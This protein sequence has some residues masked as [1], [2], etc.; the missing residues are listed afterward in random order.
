MTNAQM[1]AVLGRSITAVKKMVNE[2][3]HKSKVT[4]VIERNPKGR[5]FTPGAMAMMFR[6]EAIC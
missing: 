4:Y 6:E 2:L 5:K 3:G 1:G